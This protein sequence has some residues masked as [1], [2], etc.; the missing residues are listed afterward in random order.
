VSVVLENP[1]SNSFQLNSKCL[2]YISMLYV[3]ISIAAAV[4]AYRFIQIGPATV[5]GA[6]VIFSFNFLVIDIIAEV[7]GF[8]VSRKI[9]WTGLMYELLFA[10]LMEII[11][12]LPYPSFWNMNQDYQNVLGSTLRFVLS[13]IIADVVGMF[14]SAYLI[15]RWKLFLKGKY[16][17]LRSIGA[18][19]ISDFFMT[20][21]IG[22]S[23]FFGK[24]NFYEF[25]IILISGY[26]LHVLYAIFFVWIAV[27]TANFI[28]RI[29][30]INTFDVNINYNPFSF[31]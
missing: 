23:A 26:I 28:K 15:S 21:I 6:T 10:L 9:I 16:F 18:T 5:S 22:L 7:Y 29:E 1:I 4:L 24:I 13:G 14:S 20:L 19:I 8:R 3:T 2:V 30:N 17:G 27:I 11:I 12:Y 31:S 25:F